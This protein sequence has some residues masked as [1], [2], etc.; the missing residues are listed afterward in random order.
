MAY[1][2]KMTDSSPT[3]PP[4]DA[5]YCLFDSAWWLDAVAPGRWE[6]LDINDN[7]R[8]AARWPLV[9]GK[10]RFLKTIGMPP[11]TKT[12]GPWVDTGEGRPARQLGNQHAALAELVAKLPPHDRLRQN[13]HARMTNWLPFYW[14]GFDQTTHYSYVLDVLNDMDGVFANFSESTRRAVR[15][16]EKTVAIKDLDLDAF[17]AVNAKSFKRQD[18]QAPDTALIRRLEDAA[19]PRH[20]R[21]IIGAVDEQGRVHAGAYI[22]HDERCAYYLLG[23]MDE[24]LRDSQAMSLVMWEAIRHAGQVSRQFDF[25]GSMIEPIERFFRGF[26]ANQSPYFK[27]SKGNAKARL[28]G[29]LSGR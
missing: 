20:A 29:A 19:A 17:L 10:S 15:K 7:G 8:L 3:I 6:Y 12:L 4:A 24:A 28:L 23:G 18:M 13:F 1:V 26:G 9:W 2:E 11:L 27:I 14:Q 21:R 16:A 22:V 25:E 5:G